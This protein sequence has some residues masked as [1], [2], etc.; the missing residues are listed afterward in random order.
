MRWARL[1]GSEIMSFHVYQGGVS[2]HKHGFTAPV[3][4]HRFAS[5]VV[6]PRAYK[7]GGRPCANLCPLTRTLIASTPPSLR[8]KRKRGREIDLEIG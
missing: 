8:L 4:A 1:T 2:A 6:T 7:A 3:R 5:S